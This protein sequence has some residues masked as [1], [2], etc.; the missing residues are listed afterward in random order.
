MSYLGFFYREYD[1]CFYYWEAVECIRKCLMMGFAVF[2]QVSDCMA[3]SFLARS[4]KL[5]TYFCDFPHL[6]PN[7]QPGTL[8]QLIAVMLITVT[9]IIVLCLCRPYSDPVDDMLSVMNQSMLFLTLLGALMLKF[10]QGFKATGVYEEGYD[11]IFVNM[12]L[13]G[14]AA[15]VVMLTVAAVVRSTLGAVALHRAREQKNSRDAWAQSENKSAGT[16]QEGHEEEGGSS[17]EPTSDMKLPTGT[18]LVI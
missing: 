8:M 3:L 11:L 7:H 15:L 4:G 6:E 13:I 16:G 17:E 18:K 1:H 10:H 9:Y 5:L 12:L 14:S 2:F